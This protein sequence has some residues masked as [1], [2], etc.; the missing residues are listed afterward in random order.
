M[1]RRATEEFGLTWKDRYIAKNLRIADVLET[2][3]AVS[4][5]PSCFGGEGQLCH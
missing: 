3:S 1:S 2:S 4:I 5:L